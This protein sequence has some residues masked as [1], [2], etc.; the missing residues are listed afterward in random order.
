[1]ADKNF[2]R[3]PEPK[4]DVSGR[5]NVNPASFSIRRIAGLWRPAGSL[6]EPALSTLARFAHRLVSSDGN[7]YTADEILAKAGQ[8]TLVLAE[9]PVDASTELVGV[10]ISGITTPDG[11]NGYYD[12]TG[13]TG[14][15]FSAHN[16]DF[17]E[18]EY[19][20]FSGKW[21][22]TYVDPSPGGLTTL[23]GMESDYA[24]AFAVSPGDVASWEPTSSG[25]IGEVLAVDTFEA[26]PDTGTAGKLGQ[27][28]IVNHSDATQTEW[29]CVRSSPVKW[30]PRTAGIFKNRD[31]GLYERTFI[32]DGTIQTEI[33]PDQD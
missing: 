3:F 17:G 33:L 2:H 10:T 29:G 19:S 13:F 23:Q 4:D 28:A 27:S 26:A 11:L 30:L 14:A 21:S 7:A 15:N 8:S 1:M 32:E 12:L 31:T 25:G 24:S 6:M 20:A 5:N 18:L 16:G 22:V 9:L